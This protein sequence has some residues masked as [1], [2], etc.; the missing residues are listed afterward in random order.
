MIS[1]IKDPGRPGSL[2]ARAR[3]RRSTEFLR[4]FPE[5]ESMRVLDLGGTPDAWAEMARRPKQ[6]VAVNLDPQHQ[7]TEDVDYVVGD[8][9]AL[10]ESLDGERFDLVYSSSLLEHVGGH[11]MRHQFAA[12]VHAMADHHWVQTPYRYFPI[13]PHWVFP[14]FQFLPVPTRTAI[15]R[16]W[17][18]GHIHSADPREALDD[19][20]WV[21]LVGI[22]EIRGYFPDSEVWFERFAGLVKSLVAVR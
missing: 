7:S 8:A 22:T 15:S 10:P 4:R 5:I 2:S 6:V 11:A 1:R 13:E 16:R 9:C 21:E 12:T 18:L 3:Q 20:S 19:V 17:K 14:A